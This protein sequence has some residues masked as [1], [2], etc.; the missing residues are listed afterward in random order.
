[1]EFHPPPPFCTSL[2]SIQDPPRLKPFSGSGR[3]AGR[4]RWKARKY[5]LLGSDG[6]GA[7]SYLDAT[8]LGFKILQI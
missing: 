1:M 6:I 5:R 3:E 2:P 7:K 8:G 4:Q